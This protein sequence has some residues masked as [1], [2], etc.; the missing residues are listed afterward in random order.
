MIST[1][2]VFPRKYLLGPLATD[3]FG[4]GKHCSGLGPRLIGTFSVARKKFLVA[5]LPE[6]SVH[7]SEVAAELFLRSLGLRA[8][9]VLSGVLRHLMPLSERLVLHHATGSLRSPSICISASPDTRAHP[10]CP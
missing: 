10:R 3:V 2:T 1:K 8:L 4:V 6:L 7:V 5:L 9:L